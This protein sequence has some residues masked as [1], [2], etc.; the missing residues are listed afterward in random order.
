MK[1]T[2]HLVELLYQQNA[3]ILPGFGEFSKVRS[4][5][6]ITPSGQI[7]PP[8]ESLSFNPGIKANDYV[9][10][11]YIAE[12]E[13]TSLSSCNEMVIQFS[14]DL[15]QELDEKGAVHL[16]GIGS[17]FTDPSGHIR[18]EPD[19]SANFDPASYG[20]TPELIQ[21]PQV[22]TPATEEPN[23]EPVLTQEQETEEVIAPI[24]R[25]KAKLVWMILVMAL[26]IGIGV[27][28]YFNQ[29]LVKDCWCAMKT[30]IDAWSG[31]QA[32]TPEIPS[33]VSE[34]L[35]PEDVKTDSVLIPDST[36]MELPS[37]QDVA[38]HGSE[39]K[40]TEPKPGTS[41]V[42]PSGGY[43]IIAGCFSSKANAEKLVGKLNGQGFEQAMVDGQT[44]AGLYKVAAGRYSSEAE[45]QAILRKANNEQ[46]LPNAWVLK[47]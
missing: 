4:P 42:Q 2:K 36:S 26:L 28:G 3:V 45:A 13:N 14:S 10:V 35:I 16:P 19:P 30:R 40:Q 23:P 39:G 20:L 7:T 37:S 44:P 43:V 18:F 12:K 46:K 33:P 24:P 11:R 29:P 21:K 41:S 34:P 27:F 22:Q 9:L 38:D 1:I 8:M 31:N 25:R 32:E 6:G 5:A 15:K 17:A 47:Y